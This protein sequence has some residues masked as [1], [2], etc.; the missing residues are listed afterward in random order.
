METDAPSERTRRA[1]TRGAGGSAS[2][3]TVSSALAPLPLSLVLHIFSLLPVDCRL[4][5]LEVCRGWRSV[6]TEHTCLWASLD[7]TRPDG[8]VCSLGLLRAAA[9]R[10]RG[11]LHTLRLAFW[12]QSL[13]ELGP[14]VAASASTLRLV[15]IDSSGT[16]TLHDCSG[17]EALL[18]AAPLLPALEADVR[19]GD[20]EAARRVLR[21]EPPFERLRARS[22]RVMYSEDATADGIA[23]L[24][25]DVASYEGLTTQLYLHGAPLSTPA[26]LDAVVDAA[27]LRQL[28][29]V[30]LDACSFHPASAP[31]LARL[32]RGEALRELSLLHVDYGGNGLLDAP[33]AALLASALRANNTLTSLALSGAGLWADNE[34]GVPLVDALTAHPSVPSLSF[35]LNSAAPR[36]FE[37][38]DTRRETVGE[39]LGALLRADAPALEELDVSGCILRQA[40]M[41]PLLEALRHNTHLRTLHCQRN[42]MCDVFEK[43]ALLPAV[44]ANTSLRQLYASGERSFE[45]AEE[46]EML[47]S[48]R[49]EH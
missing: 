9:A 49:R 14:V 35:A 17:L 23:A 28:P 42:F 18:R 8:G 20:L 32:L 15:R 26:A 24:A 5:C 41:M 37:D 40:G 48:W 12:S 45:G 33:G 13:H 44:R 39:A 19:C 4:R 16:Y 30:R 3:T 47:V 31:A 10:A 46:A 29:I 11:S 38:D 34:V 7:L 21:G 1:L 2:A 43:Y 6:L 36:A 27:L 25:A 22:L